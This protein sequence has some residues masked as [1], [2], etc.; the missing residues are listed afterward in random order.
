MACRGMAGRLATVL[1]A[2]Q[3]EAN[4]P[5][6]MASIREMSSGESTLR[7]APGPGQLV[8]T[9]ETSEMGL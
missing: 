3:F 2:V 9:M 7:P 6:S 4:K 1:R 8:P 5:T